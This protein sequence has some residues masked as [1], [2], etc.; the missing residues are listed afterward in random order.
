MANTSGT[1]TFNLD[2][3]EIAEEAYERCGIEMRTGYQLRTA[4]RSLNLIT[5]DW[6]SRG[7]N[8]WTVEEGEI[9]LV[10]GQ[11]A[12]PLPVDTIDLLDHVVRQNQGTTN[13]I[14]ISITRISGST[15][16]Q[17]PNKLANGR[18][19]Q[20]YVNRQSGMT[21]L[22]NATVLGNGSNGT[23]TGISATDTNIQVNSTV[24]LAASGYIQVGTETIYYTS[25]ANNQLQLCA[26]GQNNTTAAIH[27]SG[28]TIYQQNLPTVSVWPTPND[29]GD[30]TLVY[31]RMRRVQDTGSG[32]QVEDIPFRF[33]PCMIAAL[34]YQLAVKNPEAS[35]RVQLLKQMYDEAWLVA[36]QEDREKASL[37]LV[38]RQMFFN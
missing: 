38:P 9:P 1:S 13:Q 12:Y 5:M 29:G 31:W 8:L 22:T 21:N 25:I 4:R 16:L 30:Y 35:D 28:A 2:F 17:I 26:R 6:A 15:Y 36:S 23:V 10:T 11:V 3:N 20:L 34:A 19:I 27:A 18:P 32:T 33:L 7:I 37:R 24:D 14:D